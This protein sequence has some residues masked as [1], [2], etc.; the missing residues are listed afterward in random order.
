LRYKFTEQMFLRFAVDKSITRPDFPKLLPSNT[1]TA[2]AGQTVNGVCTELPNNSAVIGDC[3][4]RYN[5]F[6]GNAKLKP[7]SAWNIDL[8]AEWYISPTNSLVGALFDKQIRGFLETTLNSAV[9]YTNNG[10]TK[11]VYVLRPENQGSGYV[12]GFE[13]AWNGLFDFLP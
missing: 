2:Q 11:T 5:G 13:A 7:M 3:V 4:F 12:R 9:P 1:I 6:S 8:S 10:V